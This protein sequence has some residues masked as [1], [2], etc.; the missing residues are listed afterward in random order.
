MAPVQA[1][2]RLLL[3]ALVAFAPT[4][5]MARALTQDG[6]TGPAVNGQVRVTGAVPA[7]PADDTRM[8][9]TADT[10]VDANDDAADE[11]D[12]LETTCTPGVLTEAAVFDAT[13]ATFD[14]PPSRGCVPLSP[15]PSPA[16]QR[17]PPAPLSLR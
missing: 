17:G 16:L 2:L 11:A 3:I 7:S 5:S 14:A 13:R 6:G 12:P 1:L 8:P 10:A 4:A 15:A 9:V